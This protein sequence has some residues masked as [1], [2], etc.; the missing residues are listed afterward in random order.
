ML[1]GA[2]T[3]HHSYSSVSYIRECLN[4]GVAGP[5]GVG[6]RVREAR[7]E[8]KEVELLLGPQSRVRGMECHHREDLSYMWEREEGRG[9][10]GRGGGGGGG[11]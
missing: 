7:L 1:L 3:A 9:E 6:L 5:S 11:G 8:E 10:E 2:A 4:D